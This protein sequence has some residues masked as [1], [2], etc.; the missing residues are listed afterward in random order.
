MA[1]FLIYYLFIFQLF[2][3]I[4]INKKINPKTNGF[5]LISSS[6][7]SIATKYVGLFNTVIIFAV[8]AILKK[9]KNIIKTFAII[10]GLS[11]ILCAQPYLTNTIKF[12]NPFYPSIGHNKLDFMTKQ[13]PKEFKNKPYLYKFIRSMFSSAS[14]ARMN[15]PQTPRLYYKVPFDKNRMG[16]INT[17]E[18]ISVIPIKE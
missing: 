8:W 17:I 18:L 13:N 4:L 10:A 2:S 7:L 3:I 16:N 5:I 9:K 6:I 1:D 15:N 11:L 14:D 12:K